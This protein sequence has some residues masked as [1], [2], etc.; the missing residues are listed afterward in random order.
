MNKLKILVYVA[1]FVGSILLVIKIIQLEV[2]WLGIVIAILI[3]LIDG[4]SA[5]RRSKRG[6]YG[7]YRSGWDGAQAS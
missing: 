5:S 1:G 2:H 6:E 4:F 7:W 3:F